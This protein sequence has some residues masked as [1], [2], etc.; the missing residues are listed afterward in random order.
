MPEAQI[1]MLAIR[2]VPAF[3]RPIVDAIGLAAI[4]WGKLDHH[5]E[6]LLRHVSDEGYV[7]GEIE[8]FPDT[9]FRIKSQPE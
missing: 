8:K 5:L 2:E 6:L 1:T 3:A 7:T 9:S 4:N